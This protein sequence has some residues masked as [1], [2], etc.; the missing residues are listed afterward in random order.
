MMQIP[1]V[2]LTLYRPSAMATAAGSGVSSS[3]QVAGEG[4]VRAGVT[5]ATA[6]ARTRDFV[7]AP[8]GV[9][10]PDN[11]PSSAAESIG[12][13]WTALH[14]KETVEEPEEP[15]KEPISKLLMDN[16]QSL[17]R[18]SSSMVDLAEEQQRLAQKALASGQASDP[19]APVV[20]SDPSKV[21]RRPP[22]AA[23]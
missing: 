16:L 6:A 5:Q 3:A 19:N 21:K 22:S 23:A 8:Q 14:Q 4:S 18:A 13:D 1:P 10:S 17:W 11:T 9:R 7:G 20:Y 15:P 2:D 12:R